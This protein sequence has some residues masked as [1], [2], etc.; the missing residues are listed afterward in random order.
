MNA[1]QCMT[2]RPNACDHSGLRTPIYDISGDVLV[3]K[4]LLK[5]VGR[6]ELLRHASKNYNSGQARWALRRA[7]GDYLRIRA[8]LAAE[9][10]AVNVSPLQL[11]HRD[12]VADLQSAAVAELRRNAAVF[13][14]Q[15]TVR[16]NLRSEISGPAGCA[17]GLRRR[18]TWDGLLSLRRRLRWRRPGPGKMPGIPGFPIQRHKEPR[19]SR[20]R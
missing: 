17:P 12:F 16:R 5:T 20:P 18:L 11:R 2:N 6:L 19:S 10:I 14:Q 8:D 7:I 1:L 15:T 3:R 9:R 13:V 4:I